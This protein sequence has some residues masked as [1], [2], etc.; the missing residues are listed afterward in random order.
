MK[1][2]DLGCLYNCLAFGVALIMAAITVMAILIY[3]Y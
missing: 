2:D 1:K 3:S